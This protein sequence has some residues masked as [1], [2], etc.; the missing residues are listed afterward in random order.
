MYMKT[1][2]AL[3]SIIVLVTC[4]CSDWKVGTISGYDNLDG[5]DD[6]HPGSLA[7]WSGTTTGFLNEVPVVSILQRDF[8]NL[9]YRSINIRYN[10]RIGTV[11][12][13]DMCVNADCPDHTNCCTDNARK[14]GGDFLLD[15]E[16]R[17]LKNVFGKPDWEVLDRV[18]FQICDRFDP[19]VA[20][21]KWHLHQ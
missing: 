5:G 9:K 21:K 4:G 18:E 8:K 11:Q 20:A 13:W 1:I 19:K 7:E 6:K 15:V 10:G 2:I 17:A 16:R 12:V 14:F 3:L